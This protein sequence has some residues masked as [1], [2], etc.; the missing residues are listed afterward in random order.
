MQDDP[1]KLFETLFA[2]QLGVAIGIITVFI[3]LS[4][5]LNIVSLML[6]V[7]IAGV[8]DHSFGKALLAT[9]LIVFFGGFTVTL[10]TAIHPLIGLLGIF[11]VPCLF[12]KWVYA[13]SFL[14]AC[15]AYILSFFANIAFIIAVVATLPIAFNI[16]ADRI[17]KADS[18]V[19]IKTEKI[20]KDSNKQDAANSK[21]MQRNLNNSE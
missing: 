2:L 21:P 20:E 13:C 1:I 15:A 16:F 11:V 5:L 12:I 4:W 7:K 9:V 6:G 18:K 14:K 19:E 17:N 3:L 8:K 10:L